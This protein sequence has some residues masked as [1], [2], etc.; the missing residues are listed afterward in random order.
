MTSL[1]MHTVAR[2]TRPSFR[3]KIN[4][5]QLKKFLSLA[6]SWVKVVKYGKILTFKVNFLCLIISIFLIFRHA[7][8][9]FTGTGYE[10]FVFVTAQH[11][12]YRVWRVMAWACLGKV[13]AKEWN[14]LENTIVRSAGTPHPLHL[15]LKTEK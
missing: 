8:L 3:P 11:S 4:N 13:F 7:S 2:S 10:I 1:L 12:Q 5:Q 15:D 6:V 9:E 14:G